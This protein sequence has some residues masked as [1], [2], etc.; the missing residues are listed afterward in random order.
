MSLK[1]SG[2]KDRDADRKGHEKDK[3]CDK[4]RERSRERKQECG[5]PRHRSS[6]HEHTSGRD[7]SGA[8]K[9]R[10]SDESGDTSEGRCSKE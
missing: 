8:V 10:Y 2:E 5:C 1:K 7:H 3:V 6:H 9:C 4:D